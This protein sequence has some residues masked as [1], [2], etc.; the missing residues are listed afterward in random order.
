L[1]KSAEQLVPVDISRSKRDLAGLEIP[2]MNIW[3]EHD[4]II[5]RTA[6]E[7]VC[8]L[9]RR[10]ELVTIEGIGHIPQEESPEQVI[11]I[12]RDFLRRN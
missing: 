3:G 1:I 6:A 4:L 8:Q 5:R 11:R 12:L 7:S 10:C 9:F 2:V